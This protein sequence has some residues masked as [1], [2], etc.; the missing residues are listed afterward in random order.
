MDGVIA[1]MEEHVTDFGV[2]P[3]QGAA[4]RYHLRG[5]RELL[6][7]HRCR[8]VRLL[9]RRR[10]LSAQ[11]GH[12]TVYHIAGPSSSRAA[13][14]RAQGWHDTLDQLGLRIPPTY[15]GDWEADSGYQA[16]LALAH[17]PDCTAIYAAND[18]MA[19]GAM[20]GLQAAGKRVPEDVSIVGVD[21]SLSGTIP[22]LSLTTM[23]MKFNDIGREAFFM[24]KRLCEGLRVPSGV[25]TVVPAEL[26]ERGSV[27]DLES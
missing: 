10:G 18:Q 15:M 12:K 11:Q 2:P 5:S 25:K 21:D 3:A 4:G 14:S 19:Y 22:R 9:S 1:V 7:H 6:P 27:R 17:D 23:R 20:L 26:V 24:T 8:P 16:G 13:E